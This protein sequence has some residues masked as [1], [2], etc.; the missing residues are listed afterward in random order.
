MPIEVA[1]AELK[2]RVVRWPPVPVGV[3]GAVGV[4]SSTLAL[5]PPCG[6]VMDGCECVGLGGVGCALMTG[7]TC[8]EGGL[9]PLS[10]SRA[11]DKAATTA[12]GDGWGGTGGGPALVDMVGGSGGGGRL[13]GGG[14]GGGPLRIGT[15]GGT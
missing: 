10:E 13:A 8:G 15:G 1:A 6:S 2:D 9:V 7:E 14:G 5:L 12:A 4:S 3:S 11:G